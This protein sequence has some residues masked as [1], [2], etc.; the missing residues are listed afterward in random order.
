MLALPAGTGNKNAGIEYYAFMV[1]RKST[2]ASFFPM[3]SSS[4]VNWIDVTLSLQHW[5]NQ[6]SITNIYKPSLTAIRIA[7][8]HKVPI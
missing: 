6:N 1:I 4:L 7:Y 3:T 5:Q 8:S 2:N